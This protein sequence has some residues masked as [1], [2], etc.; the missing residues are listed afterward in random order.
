MKLKKTVW[1]PLVCT[2]VL[3]TAIIVPPVVIYK[4]KQKVSKATDNKKSE[5][6]NNP[7]T[8]RSKELEPVKPTPQSTPTTKP[9]FI[10]N[11]SI[12]TLKVQLENISQ[13]LTSTLSNKKYKTLQNLESEIR[14]TIRDNNNSFNR[15]SSKLTDTKSIPEH[16]WNTT[17]NVNLKIDDSNKNPVLSSTSINN[18]SIGV[19]DIDEIITRKNI[20]IDIDELKKLVHNS[21]SE[22]QKEKLFH[23]LKKN[24][25]TIAD[26]SVFNKDSYNYDFSNTE[27][28]E[29]VTSTESGPITIAGHS[30]IYHYY[31]SGMEYKESWYQTKLKITKNNSTKDFVDWNNKKT[32]ELTFYAFISAPTK[33][34]Y[35]TSNTLFYENRG[36]FNGGYILIIDKDG[37]EKRV[38]KE[39]L[40]KI[41]NVKWGYEDYDY[42]KWKKQGW[43]IEEIITWNDFRSKYDDWPYTI[44]RFP[45]TE[46]EAY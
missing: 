38:D 24:N 19:Y 33:N 23:Y 9:T 8:N 26:E 44:K 13:I 40:K 45:E 2:P 30:T 11:P 15:I 5:S 18:V 41:R 29:V 46:R 21:N 39:T 4:N 27:V 34:K 14:Q 37:N 22:Q 25:P 7:T 36:D 42:E 43:K 16:I 17:I 12:E 20:W 32:I 28:K 35:E 3:L 6:T 1:I 10:V 31:F